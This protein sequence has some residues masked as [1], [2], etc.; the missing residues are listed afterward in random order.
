MGIGIYYKEPFGGTSG[1][2]PVIASCCLLMQHLQKLL[3]P[4]GRPAGTIKAD[5]M[6]AILSKATNGTASAAAGDKIGVM[7]DFAKILANEFLP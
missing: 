3:K 1:A 4:K 2:C 6:R 5:A 7:P